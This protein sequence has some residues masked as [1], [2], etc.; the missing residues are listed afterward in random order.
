MKKLTTTWDALPIM[1]Q[2]GDARPKWF[3]SR[4]GG[5]R[6]VY[7]IVITSTISA[8][9]RGLRFAVQGTDGKS[10]IV[11]WAMPMALQSLLSWGIF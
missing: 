7:G 2:L 8:T 4:S 6:E 10:R 3:L 9:P 11:T 5:N 1:V